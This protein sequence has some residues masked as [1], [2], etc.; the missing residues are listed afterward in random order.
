MKLIT[1]IR[2][3]IISDYLNTDNLS[4]Q[5]KHKA[6]LVTNVMLAFISMQ[7]VWFLFSIAVNDKYFQGFYFALVFFYFALIVLLKKTQKV[8]LISILF[9]LGAFLPTPLFFYQYG[10]PNLTNTI[11]VI[12]MAIISV[13]LLDKKWRA[14]IVLFSVL[15]I[16]FHIMLMLNNGGVNVHDYETK[17]VVLIIV[18][19]IFILGV[20]SISISQYLSYNY[21][22]RVSIEKQNDTLLEQYN[23]IEVQNKIKSDL[24]KEI[25]HRVKNNLMMVN[26]MIRLQMRSI[27]DEKLVSVLSKVEKRILIMAK[28]HEEIYQSELFNVTKIDEYL[29]NIV[30]RLFDLNDNSKV[31]YDLYVNESIE[32]NNDTVLYLGLVLNELIIN[33][34]KHAFNGSGGHLTIEVKETYENNYLLI[35]KDNGKGFDVENANLKANDSLGQQLITSFVRQ[36]DGQLDVISGKRGSTFSIT[37]NEV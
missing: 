17:D 12:T 30:A 4:V 26:S 6:I 5:E 25:H 31:S 24:L 15:N 1:P 35:V 7:I 3:W 33:A 20:L 8:K 18:D 36:L 32:L 2:G 28:L 22:I 19:L 29:K 16:G 34:L 23:V 14:S 10:D 9:V 11:W 37:F 13:F 21:E 27:E